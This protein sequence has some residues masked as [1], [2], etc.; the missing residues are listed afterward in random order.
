MAQ[1]QS[2]IVV[3][4]IRNDAGEVLLAQRRQPQTP[5]IHGK[6]EF[7]GG[8]V[9]FGEDPID[10]LKREAREEI[11]VEIEVTRLL[12]KVISDIQKFDNGDR[13]QVLVLSYECR[14]I[15]G[16]PKSTDEE[17]GEVKFFPA[18]DIKNLDAFKNIYE[19]VEL[20]KQ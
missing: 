16:V 2:T 13:L 1:K 19:T 5:E 20:L 18:D 14:I 8:G 12:P 4:V 17:V 7:V 3:A 10:S 15:S 11:G 9:D 6:W